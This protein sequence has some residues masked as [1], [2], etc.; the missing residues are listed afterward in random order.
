MTKSRTSGLTTKGR[1]R[2]NDVQGV[3]S[4]SPSLAFESLSNPLHRDEDRRRNPLD[5]LGLPDC[6]ADATCLE[7]RVRSS[8]HTDL[9]CDGVALA[10][11]NLRT[12]HLHLPHLAEPITINVGGMAKKPLARDKLFQKKLRPR[13]ERDQSDSLRKS[14]KSLQDSEVP[15]T[16]TR[17]NVTCHE[18]ERQIMETAVS[19]APT[20]LA[21]DGQASC[22]PTQS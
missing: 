8:A 16:G 3:C 11:R 14:N 18:H 19:C 17:T 4:T 22:S 10:L 1:P 2:T 9:R 21:E 15:L 7:F 6:G 20:E 5:Y 12:L 13:V